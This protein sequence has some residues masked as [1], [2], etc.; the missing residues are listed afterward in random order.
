M[1][2][3]G[4]WAVDEIASRFDEVGQ[5]PLPILERLKEREAAARAADKPSR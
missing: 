1:H 4:R 2:K 3:D 5:E